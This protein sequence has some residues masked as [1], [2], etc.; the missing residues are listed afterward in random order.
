MTK[1]KIFFIILGILLFGG[2]VY[3][4]MNLNAGQTNNTTATNNSDFKIWVIQDDAAKFQEF[5]TGFKEAYPDYAQNNIIVES[6]SEKQ[7][8]YSSLISALLA[9]T[10]PDLF[11]LE[12]S[13]ISP[14]ENQIRAIDP[15]KIS[16]SDFRIRFK[17][18]FGD[19]LIHTDELD[20]TKEYLKGVPMGY[21]AL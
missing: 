21:E 5:L 16:P 10:G 9:G 2:L 17:P 8:Y 19:D 3:F 14:F 15:A 20:P 18:V 7:S 6:F 12:N 13:E 1:Q 11:V 4:I